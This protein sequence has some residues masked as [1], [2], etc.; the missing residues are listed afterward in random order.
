MLTLI[1]VNLVIGVTL[2]CTFEIIDISSQSWL[3]AVVLVIWIIVILLI[4]EIFKMR[5]RNVHR[6]Y[7]QEIMK[8][9]YV[10]KLGLH[11]PE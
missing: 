10:T 5:L 6:V 2:I 11:S 4:E 3:V 7:D 8:M 1:L 9:F